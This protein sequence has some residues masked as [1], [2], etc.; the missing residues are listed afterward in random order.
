H[1]FHTTD[2][3]FVPSDFVGLEQ[4]LRVG[5]RLNPISPPT[6]PHRLLMRE[7]CIACH[8][9][10]AA[11]EE[12]RTA[13]P[14]RVRCTQC[15]VPVSVRSEFDSQLGAGPASADSAQTDPE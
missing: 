5:G 3:V 10:P 8:S 12:I 11:R 4:D 1:V 13:H 2:D 14:E 7:N 9:G 6:I 15:H